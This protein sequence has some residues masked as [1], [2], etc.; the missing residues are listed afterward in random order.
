MRRALASAALALF[1][2]ASLHAELPVVWDSPRAS[3]VQDIGISTIQVDYYRP[4]VKGRTIWGGL[5]PYGEVWRLGANEATRLTVSDPVKVA[6]EDVP[7]GTYGLFAIPGAE[8]WTMI[9]SKRP[10]QWGAYFY[11]PEEDLLRFEAKPELGPFTEWMTVSLLPAGRDQV[12]VEIAWEKLRVSFPVAVDVDRIVW[13]RYEAALAD[14]KA[15][16]DDYLTAARYA[17][18]RERWDDA[19]VWIDKSLA[20]EEGFWGHET[21]AQLLY[22]QG[23]TAEAVSHMEKALALSRGKTPQGYQEGLEKVLAEWKAKRG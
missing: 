17:Q 6:G 21:K 8:T 7:A 13:A 11:K 14:P 2:S 12:T 23:K 5:V 3:V 20:L 15:T 10:K 22:R 19:L 4:A 9:L 1:L 18:K 16:A